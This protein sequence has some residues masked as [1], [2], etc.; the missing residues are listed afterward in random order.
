MKNIFIY[1][2]LL[3]CFQVAFSQLKG[4]ENKPLP[5]VTNAL[6]PFLDNQT[7]DLHYSKHYASYVKSLNAATQNTGVEVLKEEDILRTYSKVKQN[8]KNNIGGVYNHEFFWSILTPK[9]GSSPSEQLENDIKK[10]FIN[11]D[12]FK[13]KFQKES[14]AKLGSGWAWLVLKPNGK[15]AIC[16]TSNNDNPMM[17]NAAIK[18]IPILTIDLWEHAYYLKYQNKKSEYIAAFWNLVDWNEVSKKYEL[19]IKKQLIKK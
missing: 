18:G 2:L 14:I 10:N 5:Y 8:V 19:A 17:D 3:C 13:I 9:K 11:F 15:L 12:T 1:C 4:F 6:E 7:M 16:T